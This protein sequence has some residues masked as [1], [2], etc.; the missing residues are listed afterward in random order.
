MSLCILGYLVEILE[1]CN[2]EIRLVEKGRR[3]ARDEGI[4]T[5]LLWAVWRISAVEEVLYFKSSGQQ[6]Y[7]TAP[8]AELSRLQRLQGCF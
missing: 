3:E 4:V 1:N 2:V 5:L 7:N 8:V 6:R